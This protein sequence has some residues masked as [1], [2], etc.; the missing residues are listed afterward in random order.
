MIL[1]IQF[2][3]HYSEY[4]FEWLNYQHQRLI[5]KLII[6]LQQA[7]AH[8]DRQLKLLNFSRQVEC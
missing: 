5:Q 3:D 4:L 2:D 7:F 6:E 1:N 8:L